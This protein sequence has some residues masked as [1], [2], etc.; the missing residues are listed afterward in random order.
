M[1]GGVNWRHGRRRRTDRRAM[2]DLGAA[3]AGTDPAQRW[4]R[5]AM[6]RS[7]RGVQRGTVDFAFR[8]SLTRPAR[9]FSTLSDVPRALPS[10]G[11]NKGVARH[12][13]NARRAPARARPNR[14]STIA[15]PAEIILVPATLEARFV[16]ERPEHLLGDKADD[17]DLLDASLA[18]QGVEMIA[19]H[20]RDGK[21]PPRKMAGLCAATA[22][23][24]W[25]DSAPGYKTSGAPSSARVPRR[26]LSRL[27]QNFAAPVFMRLLPGL[28][29]LQR[30][31]SG[32]ALDMQISC[33]RRKLG[34]APKRPRSIRTVRS[35]EHMLVRPEL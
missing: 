10:V 2:D 33:W 34:D 12:S 30:T 35:A 20:C 26:K 16:L 1:A 5:T 23:G 4:T 7:A 15:R 18:A 13:R 6:A 31:S 8:C 27:H 11:A 17:S 14:P 9:S 22:A 3:F 32:R 28:P 21:S 19:P 24:R 29:L 25:S